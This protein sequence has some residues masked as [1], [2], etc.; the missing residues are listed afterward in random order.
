MALNTPND[1]DLPIL[2][3]LVELRDRL[4]KVALA[5]LIGVAVCFAYVE[6]IWNFLVAPL[7]EALEATGRGSG[8]THL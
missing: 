7:N 3:H 8:Y 1:R 2:E 5:V 4:V 6:P